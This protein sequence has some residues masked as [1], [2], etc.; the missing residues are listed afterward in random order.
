MAERGDHQF[1][2]IK[3]SS[4]SGKSNLICWL[5][6]RYSDEVK[7]EEE[8]II[9]IE[10]SQNSLRGA[11]EQ[12][13]HSNIFPEGF[14][15]EK[16][17]KLSM[18]NQHLD[19]EDLAMKILHEFAMVADTDTRNQEKTVLD[20][21][22]QKKLHDFLLDEVVRSNI[23][24]SGGPI[25]RIKNRLS[26]DQ[27]DIRIEENAEFVGDDFSF[28]YLEKRRMRESAKNARDMAE[29][30]GNPRGGDELRQK[31][32]KY[33]NERMDVIIQNCTNLRNSDLK[34]VFDEIRTELKKQGKKINLVYRRYYKLYW[35]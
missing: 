30:L 22:Y 12:I 1:V 29:D 21:R 31:L 19:G 24:H 26:P 34:A 3:G 2:I 33:L 13:I 17:K 32:A 20:N 18:A 7:P 8:A 28:C 4:G 9:F 15:S 27:Q 6:E 11:L 23:L 5:K 10:R 14:Q 25:E 16:I 35:D